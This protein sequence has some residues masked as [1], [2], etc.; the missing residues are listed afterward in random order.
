MPPATP[1]WPARRLSGLSDH[2]ERL[3]ADQAHRR[4]AGDRIR[5]QAERRRDARV[6][7]VPQWS[8]RL[9]RLR[10]RQRRK[11]QRLCHRT[12]GQWLSR[13]DDGCFTSSTSNASG[14]LTKLNTNASGAASLVYSTYLG[15]SG[16]A[17]G[18]SVAVDAAGNAYVAG[19]TNAT[20]FAS[21]GAFQTTFAGGTYDAFVAK[22]NTNVS[23]AA[24]R[25]T[26]PTSAAAA[27]ISAAVHGRRRPPATPAS[28]SMPPATHTWWAGPTRRTSPSRTRSRRRM[29]AISMPS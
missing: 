6:L 19:I 28:P 7:D 4:L 23:G 20:G 1:T 18:H 29:P 27:S 8:A 5:H 25:I 22:F 12:I 14:Y 3:P 17:T 2:G 11:G 16:F 15:P 10:D 26:R 24:S 21:T 13:D 9:A